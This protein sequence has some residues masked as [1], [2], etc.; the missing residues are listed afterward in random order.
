MSKKTEEFSDKEGKKIRRHLPG[1]IT[2]ETLGGEVSEWYIENVLKPR[3]KIERE[4]R[5]KEEKD[6]KIQQKLREIAEEKL[7]KEGKL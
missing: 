7:E 3:R 4:M 6:K 1:K 2:E 5:E